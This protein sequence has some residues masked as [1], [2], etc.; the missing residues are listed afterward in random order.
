MTRARRSRRRSRLG[1][2]A[3]AVVLAGVA[4]STAETAPANDAKGGPPHAHHQPRHAGDIV[5]G[6]APAVFPRGAEMAVLQGDPSVA[7]EIFTV[8]LRFP[9][10]YVLPAHWHPTDE[11][12]TV[13][14]GTFL[15]GLG[16][17]FD[18]KALL[19]P[20]HRGD[21]VT[22]PAHANH[23]ATVRGRTVVQIHAIGPFRLTYVNPK[24]DPRHRS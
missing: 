12:V 23:F 13:I 7:G 3:V 19:P 8:R 15:V 22:A 9:A 2:A 18:S 20:L 14:S 10:G 6:P 11:H 24:D 17:A 1:V 5:F 16:D 21:F 4:G